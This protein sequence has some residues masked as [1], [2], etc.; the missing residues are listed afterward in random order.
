MRT[1]CVVE[2]R[3][4]TTVSDSFSCITVTPCPFG[5]MIGIKSIV[6]PITLGSYLVAFANA[7]DGCIRDLSKGCSEVRPCYGGTF[8][9]SVCIGFPFAPKGCFQKCSPEWISIKCPKGTTCSNAW[10]T[11]ACLP[12]CKDNYVC[13]SGWFCRKNTCV[14]CGMVGE[15][16]HCA[17]NRAG[18]VLPWLRLHCGLS[19]GA[20]RVCE[21]WGYQ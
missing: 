12:T 4:S 1:L 19:V 9:G 18:G 3:G 16:N 15:G 20:T 21:I 7:N 2:S 8:T 5:T 10:G 14:P 17:V 6:L 13:S 11:Y